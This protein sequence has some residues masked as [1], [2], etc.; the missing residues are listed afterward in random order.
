MAKINPGVKFRSKAGRQDIDVLQKYLRL[1]LNKEK[2]EFFAFPSSAIY[3]PVAYIP[4]MVGILI[5]KA[6]NL[7]PLLIMYLGRFFNLI[8]YIV[9]VALAIELLP[10]GR[11][12]FMVIAL[13]PMNIFLA[14]S[15]NQDAVINALSMFFIAY[16]L[17]LSGKES[18]V[19]RSDLAILGIIMVLL[20]L[21]KPVNLV[22]ALL[23]LIVPREKLGST[24]AY[25]SFLTLLFFFSVAA[26]ILWGAAVRH[27]YVPLQPWSSMR[28]QMAFV[29]SNPVDY[30]FV[31]FRTFW[32]YKG[33]YLKSHVGQLGW[34]D[35]VLPS[36][37]ILGY[38]LFLAAIALG[39]NSFEISLFT[40][41]V[42][43]FVFAASVFAVGLSLYS[44][45]S[46]V[47]APYIHGL[48][49]RYFIP[50][51]PLFW[52]LL[53]NGTLRKKVGSIK[54]ARLAIVVFLLA[55]LAQVTYVLVERYYL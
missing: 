2:K 16:L 38:Y 53:H 17:K 27:L 34:L 12:L 14:A 31:N 35:T 18:A 47:G 22:L 25:L 55:A 46:P 4:Q 29:L 41:G 40:K 20:S 6:A 32:V 21:A 13:M 9:I 11:W 43:A 33:L 51:A 36:W 1:P 52:L 28:G 42:F 5:G 37:I 19:H 26:V 44:I 30:V 50:I 39:E 7:S 24:G 10:T 15:L 3:A 23:F 49:G 45:W 8:F 48:Q 54:L